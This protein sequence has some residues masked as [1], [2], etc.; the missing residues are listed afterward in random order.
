MTSVP[1][2]RRKKGWVRPRPSPRSIT[3]K[4]SPSNVKARTAR[5]RVGSTFMPEVREWEATRETPCGPT[6]GEGPRNKRRRG[7]PVRER[8]DSL[9]WAPE[10][11][12]RPGSLPLRCSRKRRP[13]RPQTRDRRFYATPRDCQIR[14]RLIFSSLQR[15]LSRDRPILRSIAGRRGCDE[16]ARVDRAAGKNKEPADATKSEPKPRQR[17][18]GAARRMSKIRD[19]PILRSAGWAGTARVGPGSGGQERRRTMK[20]SGWGYRSKPKGR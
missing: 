18:V 11:K 5:S 4:S 19:R 9:R 2:P 20:R 13:R 17:Q 1:Q 15:L 3:K 7:D 6:R 10:T 14:D 16:C 8:G 12:T